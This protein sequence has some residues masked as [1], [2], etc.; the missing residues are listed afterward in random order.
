M[1]STT[2]GRILAFFSDQKGKIKEGY[3]PNWGLVK[4]GKECLKMNNSY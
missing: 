2:S 4:N 1:L 3:T